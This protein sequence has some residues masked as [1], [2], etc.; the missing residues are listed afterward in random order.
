MEW[1]V[2][3]SRQGGG[4]SVIS[5]REVGCDDCVCWVVAGV[6]GRLRWEMES[7]WVKDG[8]IIKT[9][10]LVCGGGLVRRIGP[11]EVVGWASELDLVINNKRGPF[12]L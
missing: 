5:E 6:G 8:G 2:C 10:I 9:G 4:L 12:V 7:N 1:S 3:L 11:G